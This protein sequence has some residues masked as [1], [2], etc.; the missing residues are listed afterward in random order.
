MFADHFLIMR[1]SFLFLILL[2]GACSLEKPVNTADAVRKPPLLFR[3]GEDSVFTDEFIYIYRKNN[4]NNDSAFTRE[5]VSD[6][7]RLYE[8]FKLKVHEAR[9][10]GL[11]TTRSYQN[12][13]KAYEQQLKKPYLTET[14]VTDSLIRE[15]YERFDTEIRASHILIQVAPD[16]APADTL[17]AWNK[18]AGIREQA[19]SGASFSELAATHSEDPSASQNGGDLQYFTSL[20]MVYPFETA[21]YRTPVDSISPIIRTQFGYHIIKVTDRRPS[22]DK[23]SV[24]HI[25]IRHDPADSLAARNKIFELYDLASG[26]VDWDQLVNDYTEDM[27]SKRTGGRLQTFGLRQMPFAFQEAA[28]ALEP[29]Q[30]SDPVRTSFGWHLIRLEQRM[31]L[32]SL[33]QME[34]SIHTR[35]ERD[36]RSDMGRQALLD[37]LRREWQ[38]IMIASPDAPVDMTD[39]LSLF[40]IGDSTYTTP[41]YVEFVNERGLQTGE[42]KDKLLQAYFEQELINYEEAHLEEKYVDYRMLLREYREGILLFQLMDEQIWSAASR[43]SAGIAAFYEEQR[44]QYREPFMVKGTLF[45]FTSPEYRDNITEMAANN[46]EGAIQDLLEQYEQGGNVKKQAVMVEADQLEIGQADPEPG[47]YYAYQDGILQVLE[48]QGARIPDLAEIRGRV[49]ADYQ[50]YLEKE[51]VGQLRANYNVILNEDGLEY[52]YEELVR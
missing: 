40:R 41:G 34:S 19:V 21:A 51:W 48:V 15:A 30:I 10:R 43:D 23:V 42:E 12:E 52:V 50:N 24:S 32:P 46:A 31:P 18:I 6:Y 44:E 27:N 38:A 22:N 35:I 11:D 3:I 29:G 25:M 14:N 20:Q 9:A 26:G 2:L 4:Q 39:T 8:N 49:I 5:D 13:M 28:F 1:Y 33:D 45:S 36:E 47:T 37:R 16:A 7:L 17:S